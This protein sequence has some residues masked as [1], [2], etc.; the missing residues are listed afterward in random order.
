MNKISHKQLR[1]HYAAK[2]PHLADKILNTELCYQDLAEY[3]IGVPFEEFDMVSPEIG[4][5]YADLLDKKP[6]KRTRDVACKDPLYSC[7]YAMYIDKKPCKKTRGGVCADPFYAYKYAVYV[8]KK[9]S[10]KTRTAASKDESSA[11]AYEE[12]IKELKNA[13]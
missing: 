9:P 11:R 13:Q 1:E 3:F 8:D 6:S 12:W 5:Y 4:Y 7:L 10:R 2:W